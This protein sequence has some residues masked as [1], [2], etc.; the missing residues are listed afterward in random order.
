VEARKGKICLGEPQLSAARIYNRRY[1]RARGVWVEGDH[2]ASTQGLCLA[3]IS[4]SL[5]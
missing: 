5:E 2:G 4:F 1:D 3:R